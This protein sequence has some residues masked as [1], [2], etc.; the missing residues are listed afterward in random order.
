MDERVVV[1]L[2]VADLPVLEQVAD[3]GLQDFHL[4]RF[5]DVTVHARLQGPQMR[6]YAD[7]G[8][9]EDDEDVAVGDVVLDEVAE[10]AAVHHRHHDV[11]DDHVDV[12]A[13]DDLES[14]LAVGR[15]DDGVRLREFVADQVAE[16][17]V[18]FHDEQALPAVGGRRR[19]FRSG[20][21][22]LR[23]RWR[24]GIFP[25]GFGEGQDEDE[26]V[27]VLLPRVQVEQPVVKFRERAGVGQSEPGSGTGDGPA[28]VECVED[29]FR[30]LFRDPRAVAVDP[31]DRLPVVLGQAAAD[32][33]L[34]VLDGVRE[35]VADDAVH[36]VAVA[37]D[38][39]GGVGKAGGQPEAFLLRRGLETLQGVADEPA[40]VLVVLQDIGSI[41]LDPAEVQQF[42][43]QLDQPVRVVLQ[44]LELVLAV[45]CRSLAEDLVHQDRDQ[46]NG[47]PDFVG[48]VG[49][50]IHLV[51]ERFFLPLGLVQFFFPAGLFVPR[52]DESGQG[53]PDPG[54]RQDEVEDLGQDGAVP[55]GGDHDPAVA[56]GLLAGRSCDPDAEVID[57]G[58]EGH[59]GHVVGGGDH[60]VG[61][62]AFLQGALVLQ[63]VRVVVDHRRVGDGKHR[64]V[65]LLD[66][67]GLG[68]DDGFSL[69][70]LGLAH[71]QGPG[72]Y[73]VD[74]QG[75]VLE[76][77]E[78]SF[79]MDG[80]EPV[81]GAQENRSVFGPGG[82]AVP[83]QAA[84]HLV[85]LEERPE[86][87]H[88][89]QVHAGHAVHGGYPEP[90]GAVLDGRRD[91]VGRQPVLFAEAADVLQRAVLRSQ[92]AVEAA[93]GGPDPEDAA[94]APAQAADGV[95]GH[96]FVGFRGRDH[97]EVARFRIVQA[98]AA[99][100][101]A[102]P[103][104]AVSI[105]Q[106]AVEYPAVQRRDFLDGVRPGRDAVE[107]AAQAHV[108]V[109][110]P[111]VHEGH[112]LVVREVEAL[113][114]LA[115]SGIDDEQ[116]VSE[117]GDPQAVSDPVDGGDDR[118]S[119]DVCQGSEVLE[120]LPAGVETVDPA[121]FAAQPQPSVGV[122]A[123]RADGTAA[124]L[125]T[126]QVAGVA[127]VKAPVVHPAAD[128]FIIGSS[129]DVACRV[130]EQAADEDAVHV[131]LPGQPGNLVLDL[132]RA[133]VVDKQPGPGPDPEFAGA[134]HQA[135]DFGNVFGRAGGE[136]R[137]FR[138]G[139]GVDRH[140][141]FRA[142]GRK[143][144][145][146]ADVFYQFVADGRPV[147]AGPGVFQQADALRP[148]LHEVN[149]A[150]AGGED[151]V[152]V[153]EQA[154]IPGGEGVPRNGFLQP[155]VPGVHPDAVVGGKP[156]LAVRPGVDVAD[157][158]L[159]QFRNLGKFAG[160]DVVI[161]GTGGG[162]DPYAAIRI[163]GDG[164]RGGGAGF[165]VPLVAE[166]GEFIAGIEIHPAVRREPD[167]AER[168]LAT[169]RDVE[170]REAVRIRI[171]GKEGMGSRTGDIAGQ[172]QEADRRDNP[173]HR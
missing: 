21:L 11:A 24:G 135:G 67:D 39:D 118:S 91:L 17:L 125:R 48:D 82:G 28:L 120:R 14:L 41:V 20:R 25:G 165:L 59:V 93:A 45:R 102:H 22:W 73:I 98:Q 57:A 80:D 154:G 96:D 8:R 85:R 12:P 6:L 16:F 139:V 155:S 61:E 152:A 1:E 111:A 13:L 86:H 47:R 161:A 89:R 105:F 49:H 131:I 81:L 150:V 76:K 35:E 129:P 138:A 104:A 72:R 46:R 173:S 159:L 53:V 113:D 168:I 112:A 169:V 43:A 4:E 164:L 119:A 171:A 115:G 65:Q 147:R 37:A 95:G 29:E 34:P 10:F 124:H 163:G 116:A 55:R 133:D 114:G 123:Q 151:Q 99:G 122:E 84:H 132:V 153:L 68:I 158:F 71:V 140:D 78:E 38:A 69:F 142:G 77:V 75:L 137:F 3:R 44:G 7:G 27:V 141:L 130:G 79:R 40:E 23:L 136:H 31:E 9:Q 110:V 56:L 5:L 156:D 30:L 70:R 74:D 18:V 107:S 100:I 87:G 108:S 26:G 66:L 62:V 63:G 127:V 88:L 170:I 32:E 60:R 33:G 143:H 167:P 126:V 149:V 146:L 19:L 101:E 15:G 121:F 90:S 52:P 92:H 134:D 36:G 166:R 157:R 83:V 162:G 42:V 172:Q 106:H 51:L 128:A 117:D 160:I 54:Q 145:S 58:P 103:D 148:A 2:L 97:P 64:S 144:R 109:A 50:E 94:L